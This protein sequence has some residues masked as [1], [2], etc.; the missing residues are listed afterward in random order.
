MDFFFDELPLHSTQKVGCADPQMVKETEPGPSVSRPDIQEEN[1]NSIVNDISTRVQDLVQ[2][3][4]DRRT[5]DQKEIEDFQETILEKVLTKKKSCVAVDSKIYQGGLP[6]V[7][8]MCQQMKQDMYIAYEEN[9]VVMEVK[10]QEL[11]EVLERCSVLQNELLEAS[12]VL[13]NI[14][15]NLAIDQPSQPAT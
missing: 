11:T 7:T 15:E 10:L 6:K 8:E 2:K 3:V 14:R 4:H 12:S 9:S 5:S 13:A 1:S